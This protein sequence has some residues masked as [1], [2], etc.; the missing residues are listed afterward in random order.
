VKSDTRLLYL[1]FHDNKPLV[2][3]VYDATAPR[4]LSTIGDAGWQDLPRRNR[5]F[6]G[7]MAASRPTRAEAKERSEHMVG[8]PEG[9]VYHGVVV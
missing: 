9:F 6:A 3:C 4:D 8:D 7:R 1:L 5:T 2:D